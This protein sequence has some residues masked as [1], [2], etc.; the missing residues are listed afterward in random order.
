MEHTNDLLIYVRLNICAFPHVLVRLHSI[1]PLIR[2][3]QA[4]KVNL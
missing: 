1:D 3:E 2:Q 4:L